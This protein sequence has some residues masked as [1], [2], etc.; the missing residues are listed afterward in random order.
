MKRKCFD[1]D[2]MTLII[3]NEEII[4]KMKIINS[5]ENTGLLIKRV[6]KTI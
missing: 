2:W 6:S 3:L 4:D 5:I 1:L